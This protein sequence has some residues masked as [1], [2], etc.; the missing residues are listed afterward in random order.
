MIKFKTLFS[1][2]IGTVA[3]GSIDS[4]P[5]VTFVLMSILI[6]LYKKEITQFIKDIN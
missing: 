4:L 1:I 3:L 6:Y 5:I 2:I